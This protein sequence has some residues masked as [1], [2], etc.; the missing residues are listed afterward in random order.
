MKEIWKPI[1]GIENYYVSNKGRVI[2]LITGKI[3][4]DRLDRYGYPRLTLNGTKGGKIYKTIHRLVAEAFIPNPD[5]KPQVN[6]ID[7]NKLNNS[8]TNLEWTTSKENKA[9]QIKLGL[10]ADVKGEKN[11][12]SKLTN[13]DAWL[14][15]YAYEDLSNYK[16]AKIIGVSDETIRSIRNGKSFKNVKYTDYINWR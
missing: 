1:I 8:I 14:I 13:H 4:K 7:G 12:M 10:N 5:D 11:P 3:L 6:H 9:H 2:S 16:L 15:R